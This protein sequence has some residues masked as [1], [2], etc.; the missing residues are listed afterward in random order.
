M[1]ASIG[2]KDAASS[3]DTSSEA[4]LMSLDMRHSL[5]LWEKP[6]SFGDLA[7][8]VLCRDAIGGR[9]GP[10]DQVWYEETPP[11]ESQLTNGKRR[12]PLEDFA[13]GDD[14]L[15]TFFEFLRYRAETCMPTFILAVSSPVG[16]NPMEETPTGWQR[17]KRSKEFRATLKEVIGQTGGGEPFFRIQ[18]AC[19]NITADTASIWQPLTP[20]RH[21]SSLLAWRMLLDQTHNSLTSPD[22]NRGGKKKVFDGY[23]KEMQKRCGSDVLKSSRLTG[24]LVG[25]LSTMI[26]AVLTRKSLFTLELRCTDFP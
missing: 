25:E 3:S 15:G 26:S 12:L 14:P 7:H 22:K 16:E 11:D 8:Y 19:G 4:I 17:Q 23:R 10:L 2:P 1:S 21:E 24:C 9:N 13:Y 5:F 20:E 6:R 18:G